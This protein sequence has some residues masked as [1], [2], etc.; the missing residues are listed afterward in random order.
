MSDYNAEDVRNLALVGHAGSGKTTL[1]E[2]LLAAT[3]VISTPGSVTK[4]TTV[5]DFDPMEKEL[6]HSLDA[7]ITSF[8]AH[9]KHVNL[10]DT[11]GYPDFLGRSI[12]VLPAVE[13]AAIVI[14]AQ[15]GIEPMTLRMMKAADNRNLCRMIIVNQIDAPDADLAQL[16]DQIR[17]TFGAECLPIN[18]PAEGG[19]RVID[20]FFQPSGEGADFSSVAE[21]HSRIIDQ[22]VE[23]DEALMEVYLEQGQELKPEQLHD[24]FEAALREAH[25]IPICYVSAATGAGMSELIEIITRLMPNPSEGNPPPFLK[26]E[27]A[28]MSPVS[29]DPDPA[30]HAI[31]HVFKIINDP[32]RGKL[33]IFRIHQGRITAQ[34]QLYIG[35][36]RKPFKVN[37]L[38]R[39]HGA[40]QIEVPEGVPGDILAVSR[41]DDIHFDAVLHDSHEED[42][43]HLS[44]LE[45]PVPL[46][47]LAIHPTKRGDEQ[48][49]TD[50]LHKLESE[51]PCFHVEHNAAANETVMRGLGELHLR[52]LLR[53]LADQYHVEVETHPPS[54][55]YRETITAHAEGHHRHKKQT[56]GAGQFGEVYLRVE[57]MERGAGFEFVDAVVG[58]VIPNNFIPS[59]EKGVRQVLDE[60]AIAGYPMH[61]IRVTV[62]DGKFHPVDSKDIA[63]S[64][65]GRKAFIEAVEK[66]RPV[67]LEPIVKIRI[68]AQ[69][70]AMGDLA[71]D[72]SSRR[73]RINGSDSKSRGRIVIEG[74][75]PL[76]E[77]D[78]YDARLKALTGGEGT[79]SI[80]LSHYDTVPANIQKQLADAY[81]RA[82]D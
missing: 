19:K 71:G 70:T 5:C 77:L 43:F 32:F 25:L 27:G 11:P 8:D 72:L 81:Q 26:G 68:T 47:G 16:T 22:V 46:F 37:H 35:D 50:A 33:G 56:G 80:E 58:G 66:A 63:F 34:S 13:T 57:P 49:L 82:E 12:S 21:A 64:T 10:I 29:V 15:S 53:R 54:I 3:G 65:A 7:S 1:V 45:C 20:C 23:V 48:K 62:Y 76:A 2:A 75:V 40:E 6:L 42:N 4:G 30:K 78:G 24:P 17:E 44:S 38:Y 59:I 18:L 61:D 51:D 28:A 36:A 67:L 69:G 73:G 74:E 31:A 14:N 55:P 41:I 9:D 60:G 52:V 79:Y 39:L